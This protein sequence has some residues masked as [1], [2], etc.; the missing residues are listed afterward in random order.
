MLNRNNNNYT[1]RRFH[2]KP[3]YNGRHSSSNHTHLG[4][5]CTIDQFNNH[6]INSSVVNDPKWD[7]NL[8]LPN[9]TFR[10]A[11]IVVIIFAFICYANSI[12]GTFVFDDL[13]A[14]VNNKDV[15]PGSSW[16]NVFQN[17]FWGKKLYKKESH[18]SYRPLPVLTFRFN[19]WLSGGLNPLGFHIT[20][21]LLHMLVSAMS[22]PVCS[23]LF[24]GVPVFECNRWSHPRASLLCSLL[25]AVHPVHTESVSAIVG[26]ADLLCA[27]LFFSSFL[28]YVSSLKKEPCQEFGRV[29]QNSLL[30]S[31]QFIFSTAI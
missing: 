6:V 8:P 21:V 10:A 18:K 23:I 31:S 24:G 22:L 30:R 20:N 5:K 15:L 13:E 3:F 11:V 28:L 29:P 7:S 1:Q 9:L 12:P 4:D 27:V 14:V 2:T 26:R 16:S 19:Y 25:F 17:D